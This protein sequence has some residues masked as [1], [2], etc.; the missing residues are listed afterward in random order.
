MDT[1]YSFLKKER[2]LFPDFRDI[3][4]R[5]V[6]IQGKG[7]LLLDGYSAQRRLG[8]SFDGVT[9]DDPAVIQIKADHAEVTLGPGPVNF[10]PAGEDVHVTGAAMQGTVPPANAC[11]GKFV[12]FPGALR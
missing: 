1:H 8:I 7:K 10:L 9:L 3:T 2:G 4:L 6:R 11:E 12:P 5:G